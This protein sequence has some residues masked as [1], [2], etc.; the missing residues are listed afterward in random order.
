MLKRKLLSLPPCHALGNDAHGNELEG[1][2]QHD[3]QKQDAGKRTVGK[4]HF[5][6]YRAMDDGFLGAAKGSRDPVFAIKVQQPGNV[7]DDEI[8]DKEQEQ[9]TGAQ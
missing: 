4:D 6:H 2:V 8:H 7:P 1:M 3:R 5:G 9:H